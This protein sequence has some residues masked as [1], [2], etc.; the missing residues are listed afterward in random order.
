MANDTIPV[1][2]QMFKETMDKVAGIQSSIH[3]KNRSDAV[4]TA[5]DIAEMV[6]R[7]LKKGGEIIMVDEHGEK[8]KIKIPGI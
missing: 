5:I 1:Q 7:T 3:L 2:V 6:V 8:S 4:K